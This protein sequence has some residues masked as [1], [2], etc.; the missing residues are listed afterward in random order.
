MP[1][2]IPVTSAGS[3]LLAIRTE[4]LNHG[5]D[6]TVFGARMTQ[7]INDAQSLMCSRVDYYVNES[8]LD[9]TTVSGTA[10]YGQPAD[11][12]KDRS[13][14]DTSRNV[15]LVS[16]GLR[17]IDRSAVVSGPPSYYAIDGG[18]LH[19]YP[20]PDQGVCVG[21]PVLAVAAGSR[22][23]P[24]R[25]DNPCAVSQGAVGVCGRAGVLG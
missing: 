21:T 22:E 15:E 5:F 8:T 1:F 11:L 12:G 25:P 7:Y 24:G 13:L 9:F 10:T 23:R 6:P 16:V 2:I 19:L 3:N 4:A 14:R 20:T 17:T 18:N